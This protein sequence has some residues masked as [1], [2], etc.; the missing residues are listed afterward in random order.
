MNRYLFYFAFA[1]LAVV[2]Q[3]VW[4]PLV[5]PGTYKPD[6]VLIMVVYLG[7]HE[8]PLQ[9]G[10][11][12]YLLGWLYDGFAGAFAGLHGFVLLSIF[13]AIRAVVT[14]VNT[15]STPLLLLL[16][17]VGTLAQY[18]LTAFALDFFHITTNFWL[19][20]ALKMPAQVVLNLVAAL[21]LIRCAVWLQQKFRPRSEIP[22]LR[23]LGSHHGT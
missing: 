15:E 14:R 12:V 5:V 23:K 6:L 4:L 18:V 10:L 13:L 17:L 7:L 9:G 20:T 21:V 1:G 22:G 2:L 3:T 19:L 11:F 16:V 8:K